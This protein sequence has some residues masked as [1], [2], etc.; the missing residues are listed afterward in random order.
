MLDLKIN[1]AEVRKNVTPQL[2][3][4][5]IEFC[6]RNKEARKKLI[7]LLNTIHDC[8]EEKMDSEEA[9]EDNGSTPETFDISSFSSHHK[10]TLRLDDAV[11]V[12]R[13]L[14]ETTQA[15]ELSFIR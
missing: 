3:I 9:K 4:S 10:Y 6:I 2:C 12:V 13:S 5:K 14:A 8:F 11:S 1:F 15:K 7:E